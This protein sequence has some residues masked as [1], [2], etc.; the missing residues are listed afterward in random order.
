MIK[1]KLGIFFKLYY[2]KHVGKNARQ[3]DI[4]HLKK[5]L[6][7]LYRVHFFEKKTMFS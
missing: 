4:K 1:K 5:Y 2:T 6:C 3:P 7:L